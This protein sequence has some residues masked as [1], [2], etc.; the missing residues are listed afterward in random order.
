MP[1]RAPRPALLLLGLLALAS[2]VARGL[3]PVYSYWFSQWL[4]SYNAGFV[5]RGL[6]GS[7]LRPALRGRSPEEIQSLVT[8]LASGVFLLLCA[9][10]GTAAWRVARGGGLPIVVTLAFLSSSAV[11]VAAGTLGSLDHVLL[12][13][14]FCAILCVER[15]Q[16]AIAGGICV[17]AL[18]VHEIFVIYGLPA[19]LFALVLGHRRDLRWAV[20]P[21][22]F[23]GL[24]VLTQG[25]LTAA[26][27]HAV[28][29]DLT[30][31][32]VLDPQQLDNAMYHLDHGFLDNLRAQR[33][34][35]F[36]HLLDPDIGR[37]AWP[38][39]GVLLGTSMVLLAGRTERWLVPLVV[40]VPLGAHAFGGDATRF[41]HFAAMQGFACLYAVV[42]VG[43]PGVP[44]R[45]WSWTLGGLAILAGGASVFW[46]TPL[47][48]G[49]V[50][51][52]GGVGGLGP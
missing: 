23:F 9:C 18:A 26:D 36:E 34:R 1:E 41:T 21:L 2:S 37:V 32:G 13:F 14:T 28:R 8:A 49:F 3:N 22:L 46:P 7:V 42:T 17:I 44:T 6:V 40:L 25:A 15:G 35:V 47:M 16:F 24:L 5:K 39:I 30:T 43:R 51:R 48:A 38:M 50:D 4:F 12:I 11:V 27:L 45:D 29:A 52:W 33:P 19:V 31:L 20:P 10:L